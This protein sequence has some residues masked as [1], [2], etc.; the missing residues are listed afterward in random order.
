MYTAVKTL[1]MLLETLKH[2]ELDEIFQ[3]QC[4]GIEVGE[5]VHLLHDLHAEGS[6][7]C[8]PNRLHHHAT[9][10]LAHWYPHARHC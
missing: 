2:T 9:K 6:S 5:F 4:R 8:A 3:R 1:Q 7:R 10:Q